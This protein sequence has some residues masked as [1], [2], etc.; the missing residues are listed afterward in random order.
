MTRCWMN[1]VF[2]LILLVC[3]KQ[4]LWGGGGG[5]IFW[6]LV[7]QTFWQIFRQRGLK[8]LMHLVLKVGHEMSLKECS[9]SL[10]PSGLPKSA[11]KFLGGGWVCVGVGPR[12]VWPLNGQ[13]CWE[14]PRWTGPKMLIHLI[15]KVGHETLLKVFRLS[16]DLLVYLKQEIYGGWEWGMCVWWRGGGVPTCLTSHRPTLPRERGVKMLIHL[17]FKVSHEMLLNLFCLSIDPSGLPK[18]GFISERK[19]CRC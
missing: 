14:I 1:L 9:L 16:T 3:L 7:C 5:W 4:G 19:N 12:F 8:M 18:T 15:C 17:L 13:P 10:D 2:L 11:F 6:L